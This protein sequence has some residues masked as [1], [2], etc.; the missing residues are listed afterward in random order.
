L[1]LIDVLRPRRKQ[2]HD[3]ARRS[4]RR[5][6]RNHLVG[7]PRSLPSVGRRAAAEGRL[8][9]GRCNNA[10]AHRCCCET[11]P[12]A[13]V[14][15]NRIGLR[16]YTVVRY[17]TVTSPNMVMKNSLLALRI[18]SAFRKI[19]CPA[20]AFV[21]VLLPR[22]SVTAPDTLI[23]YQSPHHLQCQRGASRR[24][25]RSLVAG[26]FPPLPSPERPTGSRC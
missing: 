5:G 2:R 11:D 26:T 1:W 24:F 7:E 18:S 23:H 10:C 21:L 6:D 13:C 19:A 15:R 4:A 17:R 16:V 12:L 9:R 22:G 20:T 25:Q 14:S 3:S 8:G